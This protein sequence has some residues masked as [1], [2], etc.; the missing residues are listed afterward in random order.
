MATWCSTSPA[1]GGATP[2]TNPS[3]AA[4]PAP[5]AKATPETPPPAATEDDLNEFDEALADAREIMEI[6]DTAAQRVLS[7]V[8]DLILDV[9]EADPADAIMPIE[10]PDELAAIL[11]P[12]PDGG[13]IRDVFLAERLARADA[14]RAQHAM[15]EEDAPPR[16]RIAPEEG[17]QL[18]EAFFTAWEIRADTRTDAQAVTVIDMPGETERPAAMTP[19]RAVG[20][21]FLAGRLKTALQRL[22]AAPKIPAG[23]GEAPP[24]QTGAR[25]EAAAL[26]AAFLDETL[27]RARARMSTVARTAPA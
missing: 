22:Q 11:M 2:T 5:T 16:H 8:S 13:E 26:S 1:R 21:E 14:E 19:G 25:T 4:A 12:P 18:R 10:I 27:A 24:E 15:P 7:G 20:D 9:P 3:S 6:A 23:D 17:A